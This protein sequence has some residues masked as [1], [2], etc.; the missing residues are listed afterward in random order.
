MIIAPPNM[1]RSTMTLRPHR[2][3]KDPQTGEAII[4]LKAC[5]EKTNPTHNSTLIEVTVPSDFT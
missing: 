5:P 2:S 1:A 4:M 3:A